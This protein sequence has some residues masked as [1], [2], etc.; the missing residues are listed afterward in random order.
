[1]CFGGGGDGPAP[2]SPAQVLDQDAPT[3]KTANRSDSGDLSIGS[4]RYRS[5]VSGLGS[6]STA[7][8]NSPVIPSVSK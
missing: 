2:Q 7:S 5:D 4:K 3:K 1:M 6:T 8:T